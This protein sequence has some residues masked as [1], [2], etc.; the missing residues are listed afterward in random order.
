[1]KSIQISTAVNILTYFTC[2]FHTIEKLQVTMNIT[3]C[4]G[5]K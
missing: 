5:Y 1:M 3:V 2:A 4:M